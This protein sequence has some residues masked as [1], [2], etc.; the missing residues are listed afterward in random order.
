MFMWPY[1]QRERLRIRFSATISNGVTEKS[2]KKM[3]IS[4]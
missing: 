1:F 2:K 4:W 3:K